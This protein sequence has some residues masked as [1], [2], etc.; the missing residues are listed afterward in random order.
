M[1]RV[2]VESVCFGMVMWVSVPVACLLI[3]IGSLFAVMVVCCL[4]ALRCFLVG[5]VICVFV[6]SVCFCLWLC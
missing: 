5:R 1:M 6:D 4:S 3:M 2:V